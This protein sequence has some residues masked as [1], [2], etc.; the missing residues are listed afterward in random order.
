M[1]KTNKPML[2]AALCLGIIIPVTLFSANVKPV[3]AAI[4]INV[5][6]TST[7]DI[8]SYFSALNSL[9]TVELS[10]ANLLTSLKPILS[11]G[12]TTI[13]YAN[14]WGWGKI[15]DRDWAQSP[16]T[17]TQLAN[18]T[19]DSDNPYVHL[20]YRNDNGTSTAGHADDD[21]NLYINREHTWPQS[22]GFKADTAQ[23]PAGTDVHHLMYAD[24][25]N[26]TSGHN[27]YFYGNSTLV[28]PN[29]G[30]VANHNDTG[31][32]ESITYNG[33]TQIIY[34]P[35]DA[36]KGDIARACFYMV[37]RYSSFTSTYDPWLTLSD[38]LDDYITIA[39]YS[40]TSAIGYGLKSVLLEWNALDP[41]DDYEIHRNNLIYNNVQ[42]N[43]NP[44]IDYPSWVD[45]VWGT[46]GAVANPTTDAVTQYGSTPE[47]ETFSLSVA[48]MPTKT[49]YVQGETFNSSGLIIN[50]AGSLGSSTATSAY[51]LSPAS[52]ATLNTVGT[53]TITVSSTESGV[54]GTT[55]TVTVTA[56][57]TKTLSSIA[58]TGAPTKT[59]YISGES[60]DSTG[61]TVT[62]TYS[63]SSTANVTSSCIFTPSPLTT[64]TTSVTASYTY[65]STT[66]TGMIS[67]LT[68]SEPAAITE[69]YI[70]EYIEGSSSNK[71]IEIYN[72]TGLTVNLTSYSLILYSNG[73][74]IASG[75]ETLTGTLA[76]NEVF[77]TSNSASNATILAQTDVTNNSAINFN[78]DDAIGLYN[79]G[80]LI[81][82]IGIIGT[83]PGTAFTGTAANGAGSTL[84]R[85]LV[86][87][88]IV[89]GPNATFAWPEWNCYAT[90]TVS[91]LGWTANGQANGYAVNFLS[92]TATYCSTL[93]GVHVP[94]STLSSSYGALQADSKDYFYASSDTSISSAKNRY[95]YLITKYAATLTDNFLKSSAGTRVFA[96]RN[97][98][99][100]ATANDSSFL[101]VILIGFIG[102]TA[103]MV[104][105]SLRKKGEYRA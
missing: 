60:F 95:H 40:S 19:L 102:I 62:A 66:R 23:A 41:V 9:S 24:A 21:H 31:R 54:T 96:L 34:E 68:V 72:G 100:L 67:G 58:I 45:V 73:S 49:T 30:T 10:G 42:H 7:A 36:D 103:Y 28:S 55:F 61:I 79:N 85:T 75:S 76:N 86:R 97:D 78:G 87:A 98:E 1:I 101:L 56:A 57:P 38:T 83:D 37:S 25:I 52:G 16:M 99:G 59:A 17:P 39:A 77:V 94:W 89:S 14:V 80:V 44:F 5:T 22:Y 53:Q 84:D 70:S 20:L 105:S 13:S 12:H 82:L 29:I 48:T 43:R 8:R 104:S 2:A 93:D 64:G 15:T 65:S 91:Y 46:G 27:N 50:K 92:T 3:N 35:Q 74:S 69:L 51:T 26:N 18:Y 47:T 11:N 33:V 81:D 32:R 4:S 88:P 63:D 6:D 90:D 71:S